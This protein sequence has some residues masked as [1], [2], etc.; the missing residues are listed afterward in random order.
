MKISKPKIHWPIK[1]AHVLIT[2]TVLLG[3]IGGCATQAPESAAARAPSRSLGEQP[4]LQ[5]T[6]YKVCPAR[7][8]RECRVWGGNKFKKRYEY[9]G[10]TR[11]Q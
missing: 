7:S 4:H 10:C 8:I 11:V 9:C 5:E 2:G 1:V 3:L 6:L